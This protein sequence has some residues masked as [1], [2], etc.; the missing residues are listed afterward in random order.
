MGNS[1]VGIKE[2]FL[3]F[4]LLVVINLFIGS[5]VGLERTILPLIGEEQFGIASASAALS[6]IISFGFSKAVINF[7]AGNL[8]DRIGRKQVL[9][10]GWGAGLFVPLL[11]IFAQS[12]WMIVFAN[13]LLGINQGFTWS[14]TVNMKVDLAKPTQRGLAVGLNE[15]AGYIGVSLFALVS[16]Y[17]ASAYS[18]RPEPFYI[19]IVIVII[20][21]LLSLMVKDTEQQLQL[22][23]QKQAEPTTN[24]LKMAFWQ[25]SWK[26]PNL[27]SISFA[28]LSTNLKDG[29]AWGL[30]PLFFA[31]KGLTVGQIAVITAVYPA[32]WGFFQLFTGFLSDRVGRK[33]FITSG[34]WLQGLS[35]W[36][37]LFVHTYPLW[38]TG[39]ILLGMGTA[40]VY[41]TLIASISD[42]VPPSWRASS[43]GIYRF[44]R[45][46]GYAFGA[47]ISGIIADVLN[48]HW[49][50]GLVALLPLMAGVLTAVQMKETL[51]KT[52][53]TF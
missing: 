44:W 16:G 2:N 29:M 8:A 31:S 30:F 53:K 3:P 10:L 46:S 11:V 19:G 12:W 52:E 41:P 6:F 15:F 4:S 39:A 45:D 47:L 22:Q 37:I 35:L 24:N 13:I 27:A 50:V 48:V 25:T 14:M 34:M 33:Y 28:G 38:I 7:F 18:L 36:W 5:M 17:A 43:T 23:I 32:A 20:G 51:R 42:I 21:F 9:L 1:K 49:A 40:M 26:D